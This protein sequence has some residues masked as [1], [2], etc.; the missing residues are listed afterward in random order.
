MTD[1]GPKVVKGPGILVPHRVAIAGPPVARL[2]IFNPSYAQ[3]E[4]AGQQ[5]PTT[6]IT[7]LLTY[8]I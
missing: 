4:C 6:V 8:S 7:D 3:L 5:K 1:I 2:Y